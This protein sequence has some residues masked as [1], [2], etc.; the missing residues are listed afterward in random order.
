M[1]DTLL[2]YYSL[3]GLNDT[4]ATQVKAMTNAD[5]FKITSK[6]DYPTGMS[7]CWNVVRKLRNIKTAI[8]RHGEPL[9]D[10]SKLPS[11][12]TTP[13]IS[14][15][16]NIIIGGPVWGWTMSDPVMTYLSMN[17][18]SDKNVKAYWTCVDT[19]Y[20]YEHD[21]QT[22]LTSSTNYQGGLC[23]NASLLDNPQR[24]QRALKQLL[25]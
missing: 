9:P 2:I 1:T 4:I 20:N 3:T 15:Y 10:I 6:Y 16:Q 19:D 7:Q 8:P 23:I 12:E 22:L 25:G 17:D 11:I 21:L 24:L 13:A 14:K 18:L 5:V